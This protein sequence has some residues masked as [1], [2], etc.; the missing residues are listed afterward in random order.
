MKD[1]KVNLHIGKD[2][3]DVKAKWLKDLKDTDDVDLLKWTVFYKGLGMDMR[4]ID[5]DEYD[6]DNVAI[7][8]KVTYKGDV[9]D[10]GVE[11]KNLVGGTVQMKVGKK[12]VQHMLEAA[13]DMKKVIKVMK[14][15]VAKQAMKPK[16]MKVMRKKSFMKVIKKK[17]MFAASKCSQ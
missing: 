15:P 8:T 2:K 13:K 14:K 10:D 11:L 9:V 16:A 5:G 17:K 3:V 1:I 7:E 12:K 4:M 6:F